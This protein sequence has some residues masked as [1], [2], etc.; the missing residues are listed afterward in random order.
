MSGGECQKPEAPTVEVLAV[1]ESE[2]AHDDCGNAKERR[3]V[4]RLLCVRDASDKQRLIHEK[5]DGPAM[6][7]SPVTDLAE[8]CAACPWLDDAQLA[9]AAARL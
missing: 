7:R 4:E 8:L 3:T 2:P 9:E 1:R 5:G 6:R